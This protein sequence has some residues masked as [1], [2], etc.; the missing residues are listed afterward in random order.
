MGQVLFTP[1]SKSLP[2]AAALPQHP[3][4]VQTNSFRISRPNIVG[5]DTPEDPYPIQLEGTVQ[6]GF[7]RG[8]KDLGCP[9]GVCAPYLFLSSHSL[10][11]LAN[12]PDESITHIASIAKPGV[13]Y[14]Y[15]RVYSSDQPSELPTK[16]LVVLPMVMSLGWNPFYKNQRMTAVCLVCSRSVRSSNTFIQEI[17]IMHEFKSDFYGCKLKALVL[18]YIRPELDYISRGKS[19]IPTE[20]RPHVNSREQRRS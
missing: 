18:G 11:S 17:H 16:D 19:I 4:L 13:Y 14:G 12:L 9:T 5:P 8:S 1:A 10:C 2:K 20:R 7:G 6:H 3:P 15:A